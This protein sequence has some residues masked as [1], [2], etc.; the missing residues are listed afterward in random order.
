MS[1]TGLCQ[2]CERREA[3]YACHR[4]G[5]AVCSIHFETEQGVCVNCASAEGTEDVAGG[6]GDVPEFR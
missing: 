1:V 4:C 5:A 3:E 6:A 2:I